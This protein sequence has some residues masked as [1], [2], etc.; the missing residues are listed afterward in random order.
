[1]KQPY[2]FAST[3][4]I[5]ALG[6]MVSLAAQA[7]VGVAMLHFFTPQAAGGFAIPARVA[8]FW[9]S[10]SLAQGPWQFLA[11]A[12]PPPRAALQAVCAP[13]FGAGWGLRLW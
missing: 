8:F 12:H 1:M 4:V 3:S 2:R 9:V 5:M 6:S 7:L 10:L 13:A 11:D